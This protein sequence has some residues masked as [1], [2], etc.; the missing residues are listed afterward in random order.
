MTAGSVYDSARLAAGYAFCR[1]PVHP[2]IIRAIRGRLE[3]RPAGMTRALD[4]GCGAGLSTAALE[5]VAVRVVGLEPVAA[6]LAHCRAVA[7]GAGFVVGRAEQLPFST[8]SFDIIAAAGSLNYVDLNRFL[9]EAAR[10]LAPG[11]VLLVYD[12]SAARRLR[13][14]P[15]LDEWFS[16]FERRYPFPPGYEMD[17]RTSNLAGAGFRLETWEALEVTVPM[18]LMSYLDYVLSETN[19]EVAISQGASELG[20]R[21][22]CEPPLREIFAL[23]A[24]DVVFDAYAAVVG[25]EA[26]AGG[27]GSPRP[28]TCS[29]RPTRTE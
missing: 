22:W 6:M 5:S 1:P 15:R 8:R 9:P 7:P 26:W 28:P 12:F 27:G 14:D 13:D 2:E 17:I 10:V 24:R 25:A 29:P 16:A 4:V 21:A 11:G 20:V 19:V 3:R 23:A 18:T